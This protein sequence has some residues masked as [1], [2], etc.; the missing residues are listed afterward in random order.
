MTSI[1]AQGAILCRAYSEKRDVLT[2]PP[3]ERL[4]SRSMIRGGT[5]KVVARS[6][7]HPPERPTIQC[8]SFKT[9]IELT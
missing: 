8:Q 5:A 7:L 2:D 6:R 9:R 3:A 4:L 1:I